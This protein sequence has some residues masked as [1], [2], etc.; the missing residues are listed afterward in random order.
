M[1][2]YVLIPL[3]SLPPVRGVVILGGGGE[4]GKV[5]INNNKKYWDAEQSSQIWLYYTT[6]QQSVLMP[7]SYM[8]FIM[9]HNTV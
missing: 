8:C 6:V 7:A 3:S 5:Y 9:I 4:M 1:Y 2:W